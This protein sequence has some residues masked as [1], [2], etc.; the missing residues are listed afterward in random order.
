MCEVWKLTS[1]VNLADSDSNLPISPLL[2][3]LIKSLIHWNSVPSS[4]F[5][6]GCCNC[7]QPTFPSDLH[8]AELTNSPKL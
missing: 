1:L 8:V 5:R 2:N 4:V 6:I 7:H 3:A